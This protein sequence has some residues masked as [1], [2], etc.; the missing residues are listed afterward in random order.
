MDAGCVLFSIGGVS[1]MPAL[2]S[3]LW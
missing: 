1:Q 2:L 3:R